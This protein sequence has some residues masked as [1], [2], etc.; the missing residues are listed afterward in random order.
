MSTSLDS[1][2]RALD[3]PVKGTRVLHSNIASHADLFPSIGRPRS[4]YRRPEELVDSP[5]EITHLAPP[6]PGGHSLPQP[7]SGKGLSVH[8]EKENPPARQ[9][10][11]RHSQINMGSESM[12][13]S[14][15]PVA[16]AQAKKALRRSSWEFGFDTSQW[17]KPTV[18]RLKSFKPHPGGNGEEHSVFSSASESDSL[19]LNS[20]CNSRQ[21]K[22]AR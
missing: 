17:P 7:G 19:S 10:T 21:S 3:P 14:I 6:T 12:F 18:S 2:G 9:A 8:E 16:T 13:D 22:E 4:S 15:N 1:G 20:T 11:T 5:T